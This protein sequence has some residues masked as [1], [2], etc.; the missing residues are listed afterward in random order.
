MNPCIYMCFIYKYMHNHTDV[1][2]LD[3]KSRDQN[4]YNVRHGSSILMYYQEIE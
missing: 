4:V 3:Y 2:E 1:N